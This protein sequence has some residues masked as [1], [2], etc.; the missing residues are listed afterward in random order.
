MKRVLTSLLFATLAGALVFGFAASLPVTAQDLGAGKDDVTSCDETDGVDV[1]FN[2]DVND[3]TL[4]N[5]IF[6]TG[7]NAACDQ[8]TLYIS[9]LSDEFG[10]I[11]NSSMLY[12]HVAAGGSM[13][14]TPASPLQASDID[15]VA[16]TIAG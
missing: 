16:V 1:T 14:F 2:W 6:V 12:D 10:S 5:T 15:D 3:P 8:L 7:I 11:Y 9:V 4:I 13:E